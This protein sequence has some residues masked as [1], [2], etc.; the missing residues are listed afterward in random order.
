MLVNEAFDVLA[1]LCVSFI[2]ASVIMAVTHLFYKYVLGIEFN[3]T[4]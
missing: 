3:S 4:Y 2:G 1:F